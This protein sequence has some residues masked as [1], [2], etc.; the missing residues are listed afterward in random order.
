MEFRCFVKSKCLEAISQR[1][2]NHFYPFL[3]EKSY[4]DELIEKIKKISSDIASKFPDSNC[5]NFI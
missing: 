2:I 5:K 1:H 4:Q 3:Q